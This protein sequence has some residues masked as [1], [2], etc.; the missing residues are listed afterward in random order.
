MDG[1]LQLK[2]PKSLSTLG[3]NRVVGKVI[4]ATI[5]T[6]K[7]SSPTVACKFPDMRNHSM[8]QSCSWKKKKKCSAKQIF[9]PNNFTL[10][11]RNERLCVSLVT[12][13]CRK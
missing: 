4:M 11:D 2:M 5:T 1:T 3:N 9:Y 8:F 10:L 12:L 13:T 6:C 7:K